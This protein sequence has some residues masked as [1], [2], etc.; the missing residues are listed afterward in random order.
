MAELF[1]AAGRLDEAD[2]FVKKAVAGALLPP[3]VQAQVDYLVGTIAHAQGEFGKATKS[4]SAAS[5]G[6]ESVEQ[7]VAAALN[8]AI[9]AVRLKDAE[10]FDQVTAR[11]SWF[12]V[13]PA[14]QADILAERAIFAASRREE[15]AEL[16]LTSFLEENAEHER[17]V[18]VLLVLAESQLLAFPPYPQAAQDYLEKAIEKGVKGVELRRRADYIAV[19]ISE[20]RGEDVV[21]IEEAKRFLSLWEEGELTNRVRMKLAEVYDRNQDYPNA[22][23]QFELLAAAVGDEPLAETALF[24][25]GRASMSLFNP[26]GL[27]RAVEIFGQLVDGGGD[28]APVAR[29]YQAKAKRR[30]GQD[31]EAIASLNVLIEEELDPQVRRQALVEKVEALMALADDNVEYLEEAEQVAQRLWGEFSDLASRFRAGYLIARVREK[32]GDLDG[33]LEAGYEALAI[34]EMALREI[35]DP[36]ALSWLYRLGFSCVQFLEIQGRYE[37]AVRVAERL[38]NTRGDR[39]EEAHERA[40]KLRLQHFLWEK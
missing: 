12:A 6:E 13:P 25:A 39:A 8:A 32:T 28:L 14:L 30:L 40:E 24:F 33:A 17:V 3:K 27:D 5:E 35:G 7:R 31:E 18:E 11:M 34:P 38:A 2:R 21:L 36:V 26:E 16:L 37:G 4:F 23:T 19:W 29:L 1:V 9:S 15:G 10:V 22:Q 20:A